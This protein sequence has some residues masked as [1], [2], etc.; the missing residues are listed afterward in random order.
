LFS[1][2][3]LIVIVAL[4]TTVVTHANSATVIKSFGSAFSGSV[5]AALGH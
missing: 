3:T 1:V 5:S 2:L 4:V